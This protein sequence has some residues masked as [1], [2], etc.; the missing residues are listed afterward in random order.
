MNWLKQNWFKLVIII[1]ILKVTFG[2][3]YWYEWR[4]SQIRK[5][6]SG[7]L[8]RGGSIEARELFY[9]TCLSE[10]GLEK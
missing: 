10:H 6:C 5:E 9:K 8:K 7:E 1:I 2:A 3:F 4:P